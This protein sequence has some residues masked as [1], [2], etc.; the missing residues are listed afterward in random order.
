MPATR[1]TLRGFVAPPARKAKAYAGFTVGQEVFV[2]HK[3]DTTSASFSGKILWLALRRRRGCQRRYTC[4]RFLG[5]D[6]M[7][8][9]A[10][11]LTQIPKVSGFG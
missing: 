7:P 4:R 11:W 3:A 6:L 1:K 10:F 2:K 5:D 9:T 8:D